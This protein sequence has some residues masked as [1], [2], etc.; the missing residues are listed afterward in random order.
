MVHIHHIFFFFIVASAAYG[1]S[2]VRGHIRAAAAA[3]A[4]GLHHSHSNTGSEHLQ[5]TP[6]LAATLDP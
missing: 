5:P 2:Q 6:Q 4:A 3:V 1:T